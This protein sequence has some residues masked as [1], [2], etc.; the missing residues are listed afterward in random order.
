MDT[1]QLLGILGS[2]ILFI[3]AFTPIIHLPI[4]GSQNYFQNG[5]GDGVVIVGIALISLVLTISRRYRGLWATGLISLGLLVFTFVQFQQKISEMKAKMDAELAGNPFR[6]MADL[7]V[8]SVQL[9][10]GWA[11]LVVGA[12]LVLL[13]AGFRTRKTAEPQVSQPTPM[14][15]RYCTECGRP[16]TTDTQWCLACQAKLEKNGSMKAINDNA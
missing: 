3:G 14:R 2:V 12:V 6:G 8:Q 4:V 16:V 10:W 9:E 1:K 7:A 5:R 13:S 11:L 15:L